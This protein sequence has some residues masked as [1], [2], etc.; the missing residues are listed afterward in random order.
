MTSPAYTSA[1]RIFIRNADGD[2]LGG[3]VMVVADGSLQEAIC[4]AFDGKAAIPYAANYGSGW[5]L[6][7]G[8]TVIQHIA[9]FNE[10]RKPAA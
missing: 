3:R 4:L 9:K 8:F 6:R 1:G 2:T 5:H 10:T 7:T